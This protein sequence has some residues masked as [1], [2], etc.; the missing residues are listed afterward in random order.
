MVRT[1]ELTGLSNRRA[2]EE[3]LPRELSRARREGAPLSLA[4][5]DLDHF[6]DFNDHHGHLAGDRHLKRA[7]AAWRHVLR[8]YDVLAR[9]GGEEFVAILPGCDLQT[10][11]EIVDRLRAATPGRE[12]CSAGVVEWVLHEHPDVLISRADTALY[13]AKRAGRH[14]TVAA[15][16]RG[17][18][19][20]G[21]GST[22]P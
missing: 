4:M 19:V 22:F 16:R 9:F 5:L 18:A 13:D 2:L 6:K 3:Q 10:A 1:D 12:S 8:P 15:R 17:P 14:R 11:S 21:G 20:S 7:A